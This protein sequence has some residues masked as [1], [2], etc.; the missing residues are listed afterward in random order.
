MSS[1]PLDIKKNKEIFSFKNR[2]IALFLGLIIGFLLGFFLTQFFKSKQ[3]NQHRNEKN[4]SLS[5]IRS[6]GYKFINPLLECEGFHSLNKNNF[7]KLENEINDY[8]ET[9]IKKGDVNHISVYY[10]DLNNGPWFG[11]NENYN[12]MP[13]SLMKVPILIA[14]LKKAETDNTFLEKKLMFNSPVDTSFNQ[15]LGHNKTLIKGQSYTIDQLLEYMIVYSDNNAPD[16]LHEII[17]EDYIMNVMTDLGVNLKNRDLSVNF[18]SV[19]EYSSFFRILFNASYLSRDMSEKALELLSRVA[20]NDGIPAKL[21]KNIP[22]AHK[23]GERVE[24]GVK[25]KQLHDCGIV[26]LP[27]MPYLICVMTQGE[28]FDV[29]A[30]AIADISEIVYNNLSTQE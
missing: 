12:Y 7:A 23:F 28:E 18:I 21:P 10:R 20:Y 11:I 26:Y 6:G 4:A 22:I 17:D 14:A 8:V 9:A 27:N 15:N 25:M 30:S 24:K 29:L 16:L 19:K 13:A 1:N 5:E 2:F 3:K